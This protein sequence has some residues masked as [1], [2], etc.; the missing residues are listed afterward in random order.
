[1]AK[2]PRIGEEEIG[3]S[4]LEPVGEEGRAAVVGVGEREDEAHSG[5]C[6]E[7]GE[8]ENEES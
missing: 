3:V 1:M 7:A 6:G 2:A 5:E 4:S 8:E